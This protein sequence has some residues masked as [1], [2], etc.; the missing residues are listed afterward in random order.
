MQG[1]VGLLYE[2]VASRGYLRPTSTGLMPFHMTVRNQAYAAISTVYI[3]Y[4]LKN[5][6]LGYMRDFF[7]NS[8]KQA[9]KDAVKGY[10]F[11][12]QDAKAS[13]TT[14]CRT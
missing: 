14:S 11:N 9:A 6:L 4:K 12:T 2:Q 7:L 5:E 10:V 3:S 8:S 13:S 1:A